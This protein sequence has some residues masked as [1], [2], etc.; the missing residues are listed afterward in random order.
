[1]TLPAK[2]STTRSN[3][4]GH[5][6]IELAEQFGTPC[7]FYDAQTIRDRIGQLRQFDVI[8][9]AQKANSNLAVLDL[10]R[11]NGVVVDAV[12]S[13]E[14][15][16]AKKA[17][18]DYTGVP[19]PIVYTADIFDREALDLVVEN[20]LHVNVGSPDM[21]EQYGQRVPGGEITLRINPVAPRWARFL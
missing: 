15:F 18:Y 9:F 10:V 20:K 8:R 1:M 4:S 13:G 19:N 17:G 21:I 11:K 12:S 14:V 3:I 6:V 16:R 5:C 2:F 7:Y